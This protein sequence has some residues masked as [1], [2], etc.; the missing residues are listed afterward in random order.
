MSYPRVTALAAS[1][2]VLASGATAGTP[3][4]PLAAPAAPAVLASAS[5]AAEPIPA[6]AIQVRGITEPYRSLILK[7]GGKRNPPWSGKIA[8]VC[9]EE[10]DTVDVNQILVEMDRSEEEIDA[11]LRK[12]IAES[13]AE[14][15]SAEERAATLGSLAESARKLY[16]RTRSIS[17]EDIDKKELEFRLA[18]FEKH[19]LTV[20][21]EREKLEADLASEALGK[22]TLRSPIAGIVVKVFMHDG[23][24]CEPVDPL[25]QVVDVSKGYFIGN[26]EEKIGRALTKGQPMELRL[27]AGSQQV[28]VQGKV[29]FVSPI[30]DPSS[31]LMVVKVEFEN[32]GG[33]IR[34]GVAGV[35]VI[36][37]K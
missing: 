15:A 34:P 9:V 33:S 6:D 17:K 26:V 4:V 20:V 37:S 7:S 35:L 32:P 21:K 12:L 18:V 8:H 10:G 13:K 25:I 22:R 19:R 1:M 3:A 2:M 24:T 23:E 36:P 28:P 31:S 29:S 27:Q 11:R 30:V 5:P 16:E 14:L